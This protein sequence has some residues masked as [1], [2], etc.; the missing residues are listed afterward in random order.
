MDSINATGQKK[1]SSNAFP[2]QRGTAKRS[3]VCKENCELH[4]LRK[5]ICKNAVLIPYADSNVK[6]GLKNVRE[7]KSLIEARMKLLG[8]SRGQ[9]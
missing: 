1:E 3:T 6:V 7:N 9:K 2:F 5:E 4:V 8:H